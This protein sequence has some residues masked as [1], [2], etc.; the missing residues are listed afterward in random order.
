MVAQQLTEEFD[1]EIE[2]LD[3]GL[4][5]KMKDAGSSALDIAKKGFQWLKSA[6]KSVFGFFAMLLAKGVGSIAKVFGI[7]AD[8]KVNYTFPI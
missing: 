5:S 4:L 1:R 8:M 7:S 2:M 3:E 6:M